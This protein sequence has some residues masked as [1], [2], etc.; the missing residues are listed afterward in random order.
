MQK[1][2]SRFAKSKDEKDL[3][4]IKMYRNVLTKKLRRAKERHLFSRGMYGCHAEGINLFVLNQ[5]HSS[6]SNIKTVRNGVKL[7][8]CSLANAL[9]QHFV[10][11]GSGIVTVKSC[12]FGDGRNSS[13]FFFISGYRT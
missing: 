10:N 9:N 7:N 6:I 8:G 4:I 3:K 11:I 13:L 12:V 2:Y 1:L 5:N